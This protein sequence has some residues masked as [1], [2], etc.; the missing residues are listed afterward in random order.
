MSYNPSRYYDISF[1]DLARYNAQRQYLEAQRQYAEAQR[2]PQVVNSRRGPFAR[3]VTRNRGG[4]LEY[5]F[6]R[7]VEDSYNPL[8]FRQPEAREPEPESYTLEDI[9][10]LVNAHRTQNPDSYGQY[11][12]RQ[13]QQE[14]QE[15]QEQKDKQEQELKEI[16]QAAEELTEQQAKEEA[17]PEE[18]EESAE[19]Q[20]FDL[21]ELIKQALLGEKQPEE[22]E[23]SEEQQETSDPIEVDQEDPSAYFHPAAPSPVHDPI[24]VSQPHLDTSLPFSPQVDVYDKPESYV[25]IL[26]L[27]GAAKT[28]FEVDF[29]PTNHELFIKGSSKNKSGSDSDSSQLTVSEIHFGSFERSIKFPIVPKV[30]DEEIKAKYSNGLLEVTI[31]KLPKQKEDVKPKK[32]VTVE[33]VEDEELK[34]ENDLKKL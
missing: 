26:A 21:A 10:N 6:G 32:R 28:S 25:V 8:Y 20:V 3:K 4:A 17:E 14:E 31:P 23:P 16:Q 1:E 19:P 9:L 15:E 18:A 2:N 27:P 34:F 24:R 33:E 12:A 22:N 29:H 11:V 5:P 7:Y 13:K 30:K